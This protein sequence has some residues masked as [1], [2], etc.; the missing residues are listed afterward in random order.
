M[1]TASDNDRSNISWTQFMSVG[2]GGKPSLHGCSDGKVL[3]RRGECLHIS[4]LSPLT[5]TINIG[6]DSLG[7]MIGTVDSAV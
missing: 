2:V 4:S 1:E 7:V 5:L 6:S 3:R